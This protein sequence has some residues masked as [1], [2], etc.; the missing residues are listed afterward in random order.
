M[1]IDEYILGLNVFDKQEEN[2][3]NTKDFSDIKNDVNFHEI[4]LN[5][6]F[7]N[8][9]K[10]YVL[11]V[12]QVQSGKTKNIENIIKY[13]IEKSYDFVIFFAGITNLLLQQ[14]KE[15]IEDSLWKDKSSIDNNSFK[16]YDQSNIG[17]LSN[18]YKLFKTNI[19][20]ILKGSKSINKVYEAL[21]IIDLRNKKVLIIDDECD[22]ASIN[23]GKES[24]SKIYE[25][26][27]AL[28]SKR[29]HNGKLIS[30]TGTPFANIMNKNS[31]GLQIDR[32]VT[33][34]NYQDYCGLEYFNNSNN[35]HVINS[36]KQDVVLNFTNR[37]KD[38]KYAILTWLIYTSIALNE[39]GDSYK[40][41]LL[42][43]IDTEN[44]NQQD[45]HKIVMRILLLFYQELMSGDYRIVRRLFIP[46]IKDKL[47]L[48]YDFENL[49][50]NIIY[51]L[52]YLFASKS[53]IYEKVI[54]LNSKND[55][56]NKFKSGK[57]QFSII[58]SG[59]MASRGF[60]FNNL[61]TQLFLNV[62]CQKIAV[63]TLLQRCRWF[64][65][66]KQRIKYLKVITSQRIVDALKLSFD[67]I[68]IFT[69]GTSTTKIMEIKEKIYHLD[70]LNKEVEST[71]QV[72]RR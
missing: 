61:T 25:L 70:K 19:V 8:N 48:D 58:V 43:N 28:Y 52:Q 10:E 13:A 23:I 33:L 44:D 29:I 55:N 64:G 54:L 32:I 45:N 71:S 31:N 46:F 47:N 38:I 63:D 7:S 11:C 4:N 56:S 50:N 62:P 66:R 1:K 20:N 41:E 14:T 24:S 72:K 40:S 65:N 37:E 49:K 15:R 21:N 5:N 51:I 36:S 59:F 22:Y 39:I 57:Y 68:N 6:I 53:E 27:E 26:I 67:Y 18:I 60:T 42:I 9:D 69:P 3:K 34:L 30:F 35:Y 17:N 2:D 16:F 12:G